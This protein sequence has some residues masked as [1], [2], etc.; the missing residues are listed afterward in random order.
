M[1]RAG[2]FLKHSR[3]FIHHYGKARAPPHVQSKCQSRESMAVAQEH[4]SRST[5]IQ[6]ADEEQP[7]W[8]L[9][10]DLRSSK[11]NNTGPIYAALWG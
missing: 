10:H 2:R 6:P 3:A 5:I 8:G 1:N 9:M 4:H 11:Q 7:A